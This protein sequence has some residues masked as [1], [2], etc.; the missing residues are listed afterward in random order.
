MILSAA[1]MANPFN[2][3]RAIVLAPCSPCDR[4]L[5][6]NQTEE[7]KKIGVMR[8]SILFDRHDSEQSW[9][10]VV[11]LQQLAIGKPY[12]G[13]YVEERKTDDISS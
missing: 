13:S 3:G 12:L 8:V 1:M 2:S 9:K 7:D 10:E 4:I 5:A 6:L 11:V